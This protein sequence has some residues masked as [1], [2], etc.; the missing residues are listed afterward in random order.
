[1]PWTY[2]TALLLISQAP[3]AVYLQPSSYVHMILQLYERLDNHTK[4]A[5]LLCF[6]ILLLIDTNHPPPPHCQLHQIDHLTI[7]HNP[8]DD[9]HLNPIVIFLPCKL[10]R[11]RFLPPLSLYSPLRRFHS[12][13]LS[14]LVPSSP[15]QRSM[16][17]LFL[18]PLAS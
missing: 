3:N 14:F 4:A 6:C 9:F 8:N 11:H 18:L 1:M 16:D 12:I 2:H 5:S 15:F 13:I 7:C 17:S 10:Y